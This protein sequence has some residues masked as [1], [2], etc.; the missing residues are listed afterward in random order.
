MNTQD[1]KMIDDSKGLSQ[2]S[3]F[4]YIKHNSDPNVW[5]LPTGGAILSNML[6]ESIIDNPNTESYGTSES[7]PMM[8]KDIKVETIPFI[9]E[10]IKFY[11]GCVEIEPPEHPVK[12]IHLSVIFGDEYHL[13]KDIY[14]D[15]DS[16]K[17]KILKL[18]D[19]IESSLYFRITHLPKKLCAIIATILK[20]LNIAEIKKLA[21]S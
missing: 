13:F 7:N 9:V 20:D 1:T 19:I 21:S 5:Q 14:S 11:D 3:E 6:K 2:T 10:Y 15:T 17:I 8:I 12:N 18:N 4:V 16:I